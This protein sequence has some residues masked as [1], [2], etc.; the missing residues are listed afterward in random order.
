MMEPILKPFTRGL[1]IESAQLALTRDLENSGYIYCELKPFQTF[2]SQ[3]NSFSP[4]SSLSALEPYQKNF[5]AFFKSYILPSI[6][7]ACSLSSFVNPWIL[8]SHVKSCILSMLIKAGVQYCLAC[9]YCQAL[10][11]ACCLAL[12]SY[13]YCSNIVK[14]CLMCSL[15]MF[16]ILSSLVKSCLLSSIV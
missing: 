9:A 3:A 13:V 1:R 12:S 10:R 14:L 4:D 7:K 6:V 8:S 11:R 15:V 2:H 16:S 5:H